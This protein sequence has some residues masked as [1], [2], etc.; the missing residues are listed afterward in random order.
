ELDKLL[1]AG[2]KAH[3]NKNYK[4]SSRKIK[5]AGL[6]LEKQSAKNKDPEIVNSSKALKN[7]SSKIK[8]STASENE[9]DSV[10]YR[11]CDVSGKHCWIMTDREDD[12]WRP[13]EE[14]NVHIDSAYVK[15]TD[16]EPTAISNFQKAAALIKIKNDQTSRS[17]VKK[18]LKKADDELQAII[19]K[20]EKQEKIIAG[21]LKTPIARSYLSL[22]ITHY[23]NASIEFGKSNNNE[24][25]GNELRSSSICL[26]KAFKYSGIDLQEN[27]AFALEHAE[28][29][30]ID[31]EKGF[32]HDSKDIQEILTLLGNLIK[33]T[34]TIL[35]PE[36][37]ED[38]F[39]IS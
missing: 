23:I 8:D 11:V 33:K 34:R 39:M 6:L 24:R 3:A 12:Y 25:L 18:Y 22:G 13:E 37:T 38:D 2:K 17:S 15:T 31:L 9:V 1:Q 10:L 21:N 20:I 19:S 5:E 32:A 7:L 27:E 14:L 29:L 28:L 36:E 16:H 4:E 26:Q 35:Y 30:G